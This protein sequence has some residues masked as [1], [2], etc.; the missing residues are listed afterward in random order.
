MYV[1][2]FIVT[3]LIRTS[4]NRVSLY[5]TPV[6]GDGGGKITAST[7]ELISP[8]GFAGG[9][10][11]QDSTNKTHKQNPKMCFTNILFAI[12]SIVN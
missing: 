9:S 4:S 2:H 3:P 1:L 5:F 7:A 10:F 6:G 12:Y 11:L 8:A